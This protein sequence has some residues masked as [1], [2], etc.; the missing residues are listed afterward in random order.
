[1]RVLTIGVAA[2]TAQLQK[3]LDLTLSL[4]LFVFFLFFKFFFLSAQQ[5]LLLIE[6]LTV[7]NQAFYLLKI[8]EETGVEAAG[9]ESLWPAY[10]NIGLFF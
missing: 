9:S 4:L 2:C 3:G 10:G 7:E 8:S 5:F 1:V 6:N